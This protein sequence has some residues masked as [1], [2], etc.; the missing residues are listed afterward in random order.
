M[1]EYNF[2]RGIVSLPIKLEDNSKA[3]KPFFVR[4]YKDLPFKSHKRITFVGKGDWVFLLEADPDIQG[5]RNGF[6]IAENSAPWR[7]YLSLE[8][9]HRV[10]A[11]TETPLQYGV[12][13]WIVPIRSKNTLQIPE[14]L[15]PI[16]PEGYPGHAWRRSIQ[17]PKRTIIHLFRESCTEVF[18]SGS[19]SRRLKGLNPSDVFSEMRE[20]NEDLYRS[21][22]YLP[23]SEKKGDV[24]ESADNEDQPRTISGVY[25]D[26]RGIKRPVQEELDNNL[27]SGTSEDSGGSAVGE[28]P[29]LK[30]EDEE[31]WRSLLEDSPSG[32]ATPPTPTDFYEENLDKVL[33]ELE[34][35]DRASTQPLSFYTEWVDQ[36][37]ERNSLVNETLEK[38]TDLF[39]NLLARIHLLEKIKAPSFEGI[40]EENR[41]IARLLTHTIDLSKPETWETSKD[42]CEKLTATHVGRELKRHKIYQEAPSLTPLEKENHYEKRRKVARDIHLQICA[43]VSKKHPTLG[44]I[45]SFRKMMNAS[46]KQKDPIRYV[47]AAAAVGGLLYY[48]QELQ[49]LVVEEWK[50]LEIPS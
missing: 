23:S 45:P 33:E 24:E 50:L 46:R 39:E 15:L 21:N 38:N 30:D 9:L 36:I 25:V 32:P 20:E 27:S 26:P 48:Y 18:V 3:K 49:R 4:I 29:S 5:E 1:S 37:R 10:R 16:E 17:D 12:D 35:A 6:F 40:N 42:I 2:E 7:G 28:T 41:R 43:G 47:D 19:P 14:E 11:S 13:E 34:E 44:D 22:P 8:S 31:F